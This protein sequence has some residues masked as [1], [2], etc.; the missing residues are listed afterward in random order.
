MQQHS[1]FPSSGYPFGSC[2]KSSASHHQ[3]WWADGRREI[4]QLFL[5]GLEEAPAVIDSIVHSMHV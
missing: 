2:P 3:S 5:E 1:D 4:N